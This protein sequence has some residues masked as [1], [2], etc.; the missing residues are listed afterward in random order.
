MNCRS[1]S[2]DHIVLNVRRKVVNV[3][4]LFALALLSKAQIL[5]HNWI[6]CSNSFN[7][8][9]EITIAGI[10][11]SLIGATEGNG[12]SGKKFDGFNDSE[13]DLFPAFFFGVHQL[14]LV[15]IDGFASSGKRENMV[16]RA[17]VRIKCVAQVMPITCAHTTENTALVALE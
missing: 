5:I 4:S 2:S 8:L 16:L 3:S 14:L 12:L 6:E 7:Q 9:H 13:K 1:E 10:A 11:E 17:S 15:G